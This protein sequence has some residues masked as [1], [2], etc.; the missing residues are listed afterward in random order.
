MNKSGIQNVGHACC[1]PG[2]VNRR[3]P[4]PELQFYAFP[5]RSWEAER[6]EKWIVR[7]KK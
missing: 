6:K 2:C 5:N 4:N 1:V 3:N 7:R